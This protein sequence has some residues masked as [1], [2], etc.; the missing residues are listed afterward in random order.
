MPSADAHVHLFA[1]GYAGTHGLLDEVR[2]YEQ[3]RLK[4][5]IECALIVGYECEHR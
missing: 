3:L 2:L 1:G 4:F 5:G